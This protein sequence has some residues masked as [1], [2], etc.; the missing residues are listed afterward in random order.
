MTNE[1]NSV[2]VALLL[3]LYAWDSCP[4][5]G[6]DISCSL[7]A[8]GRKFAFPVNFSTGMHQELTSS[9]TTI[10]SYSRNLSKHLAAYCKNAMLLESEYHAWHRELINSG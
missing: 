1:R 2:R 10:E 8:V 9:F 7:V 3:L 5:P 4:V 6:T